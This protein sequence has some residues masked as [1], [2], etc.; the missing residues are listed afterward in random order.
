ME[1]KCFP[2]MGTLTKAQMQRRN[3]KPGR[4][5]FKRYNYVPQQRLIERLSQE[6]K[7]PQDEVRKQIFRERLYLLREIYGQNE[8]TEADV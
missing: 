3:C 8:I 1:L 5:S 2:L 7:M 6:L 4:N